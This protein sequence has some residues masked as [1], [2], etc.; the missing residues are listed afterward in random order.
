MNMQIL[1]RIS[2][3]KIIDI[4]RSI[5]LFMAILVLI[6]VMGLVFFAAH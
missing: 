6:S 5:A 3:E 4:I 1:E 2:G